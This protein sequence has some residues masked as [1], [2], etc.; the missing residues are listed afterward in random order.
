MVGLSKTGSAAAPVSSQ[1]VTYGVLLG[2]QQERPRRC[3]SK[4]RGLW[5]R[6]RVNALRYAPTRETLGLPIPFRAER[7]SAYQFA[8]TN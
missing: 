8:V 4:V 2:H 6:A 7:N 5:V 3:L 1:T